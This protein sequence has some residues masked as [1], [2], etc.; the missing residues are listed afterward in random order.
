VRKRRPRR[1]R[2]A[3]VAL[4]DAK[5]ET[6]FGKRP[7]DFDRKSRDILAASERARIADTEVLT[8]IVGGKIVYE[9]NK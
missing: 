3:E 9:K 8:T 5:D 4:K 2:L 1:S 7:R 6:E